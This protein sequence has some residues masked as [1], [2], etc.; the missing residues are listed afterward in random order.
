VLVPIVGNNVIPLG[1]AEASDER[2]D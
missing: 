1:R 2:H